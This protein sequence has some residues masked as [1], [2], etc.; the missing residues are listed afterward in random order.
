M[1]LEMMWAEPGMMP[2]RNPSTEPRAIGQADCRHSSRVGNSSRSFGAVTSPFTCRL[3]V[4]SN[5]P[6]PNRPTA[7]GTMPMPSPS[8]LMPNEK[9]KCPVITSM[10]MVPKNSPTAAIR[11]VRVS[12]VVDM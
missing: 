2:I 5:S 11:S 8:S 6:N 7:T 9:R 4:A 1:K 3:G 10:P 12:E